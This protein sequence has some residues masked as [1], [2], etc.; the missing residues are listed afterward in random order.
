MTYWDFQQY[1]V[2]LLANQP[3]LIDGCETNPWRAMASLTPQLRETSTEN[4]EA[5]VPAKLWLEVFGLPANYLSRTLVSSGVRHSLSLIFPALAARGARLLVPADVYPL[6]SHLAREAGVGV[7]LFPT[8]PELQIPDGGDWLLIPNPLKPAGRWLGDDEVTQIQEWLRA[9]SDR[10]L[11]LDIVYTFHRRLP[12]STRKLLDG[13]QTILLHS[14][15]KGWL[16]QQVFGVALVPECERE[17]LGRC[18]KSAILEPSKIAAARS[19]L[20]EEK[21]PERVG[22]EIS[23]R[24][25]G[26]LE[27]LPSEV[28]E[29]IRAARGASPAGYLTAVPFEANDLLQRYRLLTAPLSIFGSNPGDYCVISCLGFAQG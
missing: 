7:L 25:S 1:R 22:E 20:T 13:E 2:G 12:A 21:Y 17:R 23:R 6:Y 4:T 29:A 15:S 10:R 11:L 24:R 9:N 16:H 3:D 5:S 27:Q 19:L 18:F 28:S 26:M 14:L 8:I